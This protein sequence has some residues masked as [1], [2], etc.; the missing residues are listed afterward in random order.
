MIE[1]GSVIELLPNFKSKD[2]PSRYKEKMVEEFKGRS[3]QIFQF[4][5][6]N[7]LSGKRR[8]G[9]MFI[10][11]QDCDRDLRVGD[12]VVVKELLSVAKDFYYTHVRVTVE[13]EPF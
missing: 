9:Q 7:F 5:D 8:I 13:D 2:D 10:D 11:I 4:R 6:V 12:K 1:K 3:V